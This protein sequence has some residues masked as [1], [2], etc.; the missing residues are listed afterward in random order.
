MRILLIALMMS[1]GACSGGKDLA[2]S[3]QA[4]ARFHEQLNSNQ[5]DEIYKNASPEWKGASSQAD[6]QKLF[7]A[8]RKKLGP[9]QSGKQVGWRANYG[10]GGSTVVVQYD[11]KYEKGA[12][13]EIFTYRPSDP[14]PV[15][16]GYN[17]NSPVLITG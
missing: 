14:T 13:T 11:S 9:F 2:R 16:I 4:I 5:F 6:S 8:V 7:A 3:E 12:A 17:I 15:L 1:L 10:T